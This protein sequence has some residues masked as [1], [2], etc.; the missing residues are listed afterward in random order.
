MEGILIPKQQIAA[1]ERSY[2]R[3]ILQKSWISDFYGILLK[4]SKEFPP[5][6]K[7][8]DF[9]KQIIILQN[10]IS[11]LIMHAKGIPLA[12]MKVGKIGE[13][14]RKGEMNIKV[15]LYPL[16]IDSLIL[17]IKKHDKQCDDE[18]ESAWREV[19]QVGVDLI[20]SKYNN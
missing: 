3:C 20:I 17:S 5:Y 15:H 14:H 12:E 6:F 11:F 10:A 8:T 4:S 7:K 16:W 2:Q 9:S 19:L 13:T 1:V 18:I